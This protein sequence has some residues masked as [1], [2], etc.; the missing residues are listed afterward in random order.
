MTVVIRHSFEIFA[1]LYREAPAVRF[2]M[3]L[4][5]AFWASL[6][7][8]SWGAFKLSQVRFQPDAIA[9]GIPGFLYRLIILPLEMVAQSLGGAD[10]SLIPI[11]LV[12]LM[13]T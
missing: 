1:F 3:L 7:N 4:R 9:T 10:L 6:A 8:L 12:A 11:R 13:A 2:G 5:A